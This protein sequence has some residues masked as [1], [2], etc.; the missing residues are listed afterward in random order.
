MRE[1]AARRPY[2]MSSASL[3]HDDSR[4]LSAFIGAH[5]C[6]QHHIHD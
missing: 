2:T 4:M 3:I 5:F 6:R 1:R